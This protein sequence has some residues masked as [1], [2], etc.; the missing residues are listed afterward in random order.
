MRRGTTLF[1]KGGVS[2]MQ[3][4]SGQGRLMVKGL[5]DDGGY[6][7]LTA[8]IAW[9]GGELRSTCT[10]PLSDRCK[11]AVAL[12]LAFLDAPPPMAA[13]EAPAA[14]G[15]R[16]GQDIILYGLWVAPP[17]K[18][19]EGLYARP[20]CLWLALDVAKIRSDGTPG[21][22]RPMP[23]WAPQTNPD[24]RDEDRA[25][26]AITQPYYQE[27]GR[28]FSSPYARGIPLREAMVAPVL[29]AL[30]KCPFVY[31]GGRQPIAIQPDRPLHSRRLSPWDAEELL[32]EEDGTPIPLP[33]GKL[34]GSDPAW[35]LLEDSFRPVIEAELPDLSALDDEPAPAPMPLADAKAHAPARPDPRLTLSEEGDRL[36]VKLTFTYGASTPI[37]P[38]D[39]RE[40]VGGEWEGEWGVWQRD[41]DAEAAHVRRLSACGL[42]ARG[43]GHWLGWG[44]AALSFLI[45]EVPQLI[46]DGWQVFGE[47]RLSKLRVNR[48]RT[49]VSLRL[50]SGIDWLDLS[51]RLE[52]DGLELSAEALRDVLKSRTRFVKLG[53][54]SFAKLPTD[55][56][57]A[58][59][60]L[61]EALGFE[62]RAEGNGLEQRLPL[63]MATW[64]SDLLRSADA[65]VADDHWES[66]LPRLDALADLEER[67]LPRE[68]N[69]ELRPYQRKGVDFL[70]FLAEHGLHGILADDMGL[71]KTI[72]AIA[73]LLR[74][75]EEGKAGP[76]LL[77]AP[78][79][80]VYNWEQELSRFAP[81]LKTLV[82]HGSARRERFGEIAD[83]DVVVTSYAL[84]RRDQELLAKQQFHYLILDE[85]QNIKNPQSQAAKAAGRLQSH[86]RLCLTGTPLENNLLELWS[87]FNF[88]MPGLLGTERR[89]RERYLGAMQG[90]DPEA[91]ADLRHRTRPFI[92]RRLKAEVAQDLPPRTEMV[93]YCELGVE[94]RRFYNE[95]LMRVR[96]EIFAT[97]DRLGMGRAHLN[98]LE[99][100][101]RLRQICCDPRL[102]I[103]DEREIPSAKMDLFMELVGEITAEGHRVLVFSQFVKV[104]QALRVRLTEAGV[105]T[106]YLDGSTKDRLERA[107]RFNA[108][109]VPVFLISLKAGGTGLNLTGADYVV[110]FDP[111]WNPAV[112]DQAT[113]RAHRIGQTRHVFSYKLIAKDT[114]EEKVLALQERKRQMV[115]DVLGS[116]EF[117]QQLSREDLDFLLEPVAP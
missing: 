67:P 62:I 28:D 103:R 14:S 44:D 34:V 86:H 99:A 65:S 73:L 72:Q 59:R 9:G 104:L 107:T 24:F 39:L 40:A 51:T 70:S 12:A 116:T 50:K 91:M 30:Q 8:T 84:L 69:G 42:D 110:H 21:P 98:I 117:A 68:F 53:D 16:P 36:L 77:V 113:D 15:F 80:V 111:W 3:V 66:F 1:K 20:Q 60:H 2:A 58:Q 13:E 35:I 47:E 87:L 25:I 38:A 33:P 4:Q 106:E 6:S 29:A 64:V 75:K 55:W 95:T 90:S 92:L 109:D 102:V 71:G 27:H 57:S 105:A 83:V 23:I 17:P 45:D 61:G 74:D 101:L 79:S 112:E 63:Y 96:G 18:K 5:V 100:L 22:G 37:G 54:G 11:H 52:I 82:L 97:V 115:R 94:Q 26:L 32:S 41:G 48:G 49:R 89:F 46:A 81:N 85:A 7:P 43:N 93:S 108:S 78:T 56:L 114:I 10:C 19:L 88:L 76:S 31:G